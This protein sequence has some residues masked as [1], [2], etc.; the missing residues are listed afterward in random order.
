MQFQKNI[1]LLEAESTLDIKELTEFVVIELGSL[2]Q[3][4]KTKSDLLLEILKTGDSYCIKAMI[5]EIR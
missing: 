2:V 4:K 5:S 1:D 3:K